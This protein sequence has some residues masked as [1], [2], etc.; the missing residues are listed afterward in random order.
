MINWFAIP[1][2]DLKRAVRFYN[3]VL[4]CQLEVHQ[5]GG[6]E[7]AFF[8]SSDGGVGGHIF[9]DGRY[10]PSSEGPLLFLK[11]N[12]QENIVVQR[13][14]EAGGEVLIPKTRINDKSG[15]ITVLRDSEGNKIAIQI[16]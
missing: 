2:L 15:Y 11:G 10:K 5:I 3:L 13:I 4:D 12:C 6:T 16:K 8:P 1:A 14:E 7:M 9:T